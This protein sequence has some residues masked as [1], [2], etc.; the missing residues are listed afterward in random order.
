VNRS[1][2]QLRQRAARRRE[3]ED[4]VVAVEAA[5]ITGLVFLLIFGILEFTFIGRD[6]V[7]VTSA[8]RVGARIASTA[9]DAGP[10]LAEETDEVPCPSKMV[11]ELAQQAA[12]EIGR[13]VSALDKDSIRHILVY[14]AN[15]SGNPSVPRE[16]PTLEACVSECVAYKWYP[17]QDRFRYFQGGWNS[18]LIDACA[19][20]RKSVDGSSGKLDTVGV[21]VVVDHNLMTGIFGRSMELSDHA[22]MKFEP[23]AN[24]GCAAG[25]HA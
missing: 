14:K 13:T 16:A 19:T 3:D 4:G 18:S 5:L 8:A 15:Q 24:K 25:E 7:G 20:S 9:A 10:C 12:D 21:K 2:V 23:L 11:P 6:Y 1:R 17:G 22:V